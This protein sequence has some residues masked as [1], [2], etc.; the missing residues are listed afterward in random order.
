MH[1]VPAHKLLR[2]QMVPGQIVLLHGH[3]VHA[4]DA[5]ILGAWAPYIYFYMKQDTHPAESFGRL[6]A[7]MFM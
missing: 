4:G 3:A 2:L 7:A 1:A 6:F 5:V